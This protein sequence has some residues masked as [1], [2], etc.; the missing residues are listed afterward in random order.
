MNNARSI[1]EQAV[2]RG[3]CWFSS[4]RAIIPLP[5]D[6]YRTKIFSGVLRGMYFSMPQLE[7]AAF[8]LGTYERHLVA[9]I[10]THVQPGAITYD[11][12]ANAGYLTL[13]MAKLVGRQ[14]HIFA[15][16]P[17]PKNIKA[18][19]ANL[20]INGLSNVTAV[21][22]AVSNNSGIVTFASFDYSLVGHIAQDNTP[23]DANLFQVESTSLDDFV[24]IE[25]N[26]KP[27][28]I[29][30]DVE[31]AE[32]QVLRG[33]LRVLRDVRPVIL[34]EI[35]GGNTWQNVSELMKTYNYGFQLLTGGWDMEKDNLGDVLFVP[36]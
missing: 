15:F 7:R 35:R 32:E 8:A 26:P 13:V 22:K 30:I 33:A 16:E 10:T 4:N 23:D 34:A 1:L 29:K 11:I 20:Q 24:F 25:N 6:L 2:L 17:D 14:G 36:V 12:G 28:F 5:E 3:L 19:E 31:G 27:T 18:L 9:T 21:A